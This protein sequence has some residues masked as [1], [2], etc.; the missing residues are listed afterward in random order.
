MWSL[1]TLVN[2]NHVDSHFNEIFSFV[3][4]GSMVNNWPQ[5]QAIK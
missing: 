1:V 2:D 3:Y 4:N 5:N